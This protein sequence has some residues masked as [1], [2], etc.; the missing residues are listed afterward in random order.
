MPQ[1]ESDEAPPE[2]R[3]PWRMRFHAWWEGYDLIVHEKMTEDEAPDTEGQ[4]PDTEGQEAVEEAPEET[5]P[6]FAEPWPPERVTMIQRIWGEG[7]TSPGGGFHILDLIKPLDLQA[8]RNLLH[9]G[10]GMG[11][12]ARLLAE[13]FN[14]HA[15]GWEPHRELAAATRREVR[16]YDP[17]RMADEAD[18]FDYIFAKEVFFKLADKDSLLEFLAGKLAERGHM[19]FTDYVLA[20]DGRNDPAVQAWLGAEPFPRFPISLDE[21]LA[22]L[23]RHALSVRS[24]EDMTSTHSQMVQRGWEYFLESL[25]EE[26]PDSTQLASLRIELEVWACRMQ[27]MET[28]KLKVYRIHARRA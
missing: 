14:V 28:G 17:D 24:S 1:E 22:V 21:H 6:A 19:L 26:K 20:E 2:T 23:E 27:A 8:G 25:V 9:F 12:P 16:A 13:T 15:T 3:V 4:A 18:L 7:F 10:A 5:E 11:G